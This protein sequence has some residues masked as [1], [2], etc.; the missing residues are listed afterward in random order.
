VT[1]FHKI[2]L[3]CILGHPVHIGTF[4]LQKTDSI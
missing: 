2:A 3:A 1:L 4:I